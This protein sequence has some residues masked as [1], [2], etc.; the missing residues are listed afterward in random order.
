LAAP[1]GFLEDKGLWMSDQV[2]HDSAFLHGFLA[3]V[4]DTKSFDVFRSQLSS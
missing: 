3:F 2:R 1:K 4:S